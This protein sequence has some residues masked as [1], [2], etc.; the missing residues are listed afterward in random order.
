MPGPLPLHPALSRANVEHYLAG[1][2]PYPD[3][4]IQ[5]LAEL[6]AL[7]PNHRV[8]DLGCGPG[9]LAL[10][11]AHYAAEVVA[12]DPEPEMLAAAQAQ[13]GDRYP[14]VRF[15]QGSSERLSPELGQF[16]LV[17]MGRSF[18]WMN[19]E[20]TLLD[21]HSRVH[22]GGALAILEERYLDLPENTWWNHYNK[23]FSS[24]ANDLPARLGAMPRNETILFNSPFSRLEKF[25]V[26]LRVESS[27][28]R[29]LNRALSMATLSEEF[30]GPR[31][32]LFIKS[33]RE[34]LSLYAKEE[35]IT[36]VVEIGG[37]LAFRP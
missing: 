29:L 7:Q 36:E 34:V 25:F 24:F 12:L 23:V 33:I 13:A 3:Q 27:I 6:S 5:R 26:L 15:I 10:A 28:E 31:R 8:L 19:R 21:L 11:L 32:Q 2:L 30:T 35:T 18:H 14:S 9:Y 37:I 17:T 1:R 4:L 20:S 22:P 16:H